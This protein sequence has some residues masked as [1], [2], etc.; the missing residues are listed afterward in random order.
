MAIHPYT[1]CTHCTY[2]TGKIVY[3]CTAGVLCMYLVHIYIGINITQVLGRGNDMTVLIHR[4]E[5]VVQP[6]SEPCTYVHIHR[7]SHV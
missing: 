4:Y 7:S 3:R 2:S 5:N 6:A 1:I